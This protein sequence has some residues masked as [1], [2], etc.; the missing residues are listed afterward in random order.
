MI[1]YGYLLE[2]KTALEIRLL[3]ALLVAI[4]ETVTA[5]WFE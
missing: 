4:S 5:P 2:A 3:Y 1:N